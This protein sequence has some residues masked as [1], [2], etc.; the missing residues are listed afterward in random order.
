[1]E[2]KGRLGLNFLELLQK[3]DAKLKTLL[4]G[5]TAPAAHLPSV[6]HYDDSD[7]PSG[8]QKTIRG[9]ERF[10]GTECCVWYGR[11][12]Y[13][14]RLWLEHPFPSSVLSPV[15]SFIFLRLRTSLSSICFILV[16]VV[17][18]DRQGDVDNARRH[19]VIFSGLRF[20]WAYSV[21]IWRVCGCK[22]WDEIESNLILFNRKAWTGSF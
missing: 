15:H 17:R 20:V 22:K 4:A 2:L 8:R 12:G 16:S 10:Q 5:W 18:F 3:Y 7:M 19:T 1:M 21:S 11:V 13:S 9:Q 6:L 14:S